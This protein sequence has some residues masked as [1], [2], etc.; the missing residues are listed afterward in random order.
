MN[1][2]WAEKEIME[3]TPFILATSNINY[4]GVILTSERHE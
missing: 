1:D 2:K 4:I 3:T